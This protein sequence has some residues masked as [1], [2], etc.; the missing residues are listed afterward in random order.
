MVDSVHRGHYRYK[1]MTDRMDASVEK[2]SGPADMEVSSDKLFCCR[3]VR[4]KVPLTYREEL[5]HI[6]RMTGPLV[7]TD[8]VC[9]HFSSCVSCDTCITSGTFLV[10]VFLAAVSNPQ[11]HASVCGY[12]VLWPSGKRCDG[13]LWISFRCKWLSVEADVRKS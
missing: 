11:L 4:N 12:N 8:T 2:P 9:L 10:F 13:R 1:Y 7:N 6:L 5:Y 3:G